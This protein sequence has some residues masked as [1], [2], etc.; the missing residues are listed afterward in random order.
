MV[1]VVNHITAAIQIVRRKLHI[2]RG[3]ERD[4][5]KRFNLITDCQRTED[6]YKRKQPA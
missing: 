4:V 6:I 3:I 5:G 1:V 2:E